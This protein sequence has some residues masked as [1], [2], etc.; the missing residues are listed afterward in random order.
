MFSD[1]VPFPLKSIY[2]LGFNVGD[3]TE[4]RLFSDLHLEFDDTFTIRNLKPNQII[5]LAGDIHVKTRGIPWIKEILKHGNHVV[6]VAGNHEFYKTQMY[7]VIRAYTKLENEFENF[8]FLN[9]SSVIINNIEFLGGTLWTNMDN[10]NPEVYIPLGEKRFDRYSKKG[11]WDYRYIY[12]DRDEPNNKKRYNVLKTKDTVRL[13]KKTVAYLKSRAGKHPTQFVV[14]HHTP[15]SVFLNSK[16]D[17]ENPLSRFSYYSEL[18]DLAKKFSY[19]AAGHTHKKVDETI[20]GVRYLSEPRGYSKT[21]NPDDDYVQD[22]Q[23][24]KIIKITA[25]PL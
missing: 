9:D 19:W 24:N 3:D 14:T 13:H 11:M 5:I 2:T 20:D 7:K 21:K 16:R 18:H 12:V 4:V 1:S 23:E 17:K 10:E 8:H 25:K 15:H 22:F 6:F